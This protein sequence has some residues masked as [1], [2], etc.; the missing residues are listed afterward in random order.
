M[1]KT[2]L[3]VIIFLSAFSGSTQEDTLYFSEA[4]SVH[5]PKYQ[6]KARQ[7]YQEQDIERADFLFDSLV[8]HCLKR[9]YLDNF[10][11]K[12]L[13]GKNVH[14]RNFS[15][16]LFLVTYATWLTPAEGEI[17]A[18][19][20]LAKEYEGE[21]DFVVL[22]WDSRRATKKF[23]KKYGKEINV[24]YVDEATNNNGKVVSTL[25]HALGLPMIF[26]LGPDKQVLDIRRNISHPYGIPLKD[27]YTLS[28]NTYSTGLSLLANS[29]NNQETSSR[30][31]VLQD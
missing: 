13:N 11:I 21:A 20:K 29:Q 3:V 5:L 24:M 18:L 16:P 10:R 8:Q 31:V 2:L 19:K 17:P 23:A 1:G 22:F 30:A 26:F 7:A 27:S 14:L 28:Y 6:E 25:K 12:D 9:S 15:K 4:L